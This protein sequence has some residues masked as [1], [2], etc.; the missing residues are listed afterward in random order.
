MLNW[1]LIYFDAAL[2][3]DA[4]LGAD[5]DVNCFQHEFKSKQYIFSKLS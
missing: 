3:A 4:D 1:M 5:F 2:D